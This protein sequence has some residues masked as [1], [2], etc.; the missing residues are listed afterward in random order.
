MACMVTAYIALAYV[1]MAYMVTAY[2]A[3][4]YVVTAYK[5]AAYVATAS[6]GLYSYCPP[7]WVRPIQLWPT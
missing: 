3:L 4:A 7:T 2:V 1:V 5:L 6:Y